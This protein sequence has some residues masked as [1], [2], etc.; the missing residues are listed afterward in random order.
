M[1]NKITWVVCAI[2][3]VV[4]VW[5]AVTMH[6]NTEQAEVQHSNDVLV[7]VDHS[8]HLVQTSAQLETVKQDKLA[9]EKDLAGPEGGYHQAVQ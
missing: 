5:E 4:I 8:N 6:H 2:L 1:N 3:V 9:V 7:I